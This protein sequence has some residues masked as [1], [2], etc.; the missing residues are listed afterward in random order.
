[1]ALYDTADLV[2]KFRRLA[3]R[4][5]DDEDLQDTDIYAYLTDA[6][7]PE[8]EAIAARFPNVLMGAPVLMTSSDGGYTYTF[9]TDSEGSEIYPIGHCEVF[10]K[11]D[12][13]ELYGSTF[14]AYNGDVVFEGSRVRIPAGQTKSFDSGPYARYVSLPLTISASAEP[15]LQP[16]QHRNLILYRALIMWANTGGHRDPRP[17][18]QLYDRAWTAVVEALTTQYR[19]KNYASLAGIAYWRAWMANGGHILQGQEGG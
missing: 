2:A 16:K 14:G 6:Q 1:M 18:E 13:R 5:E 15:T 9:G 4:P 11:L 3:D 7:I 12:G 19:Q 8:M 17:Y 10:A